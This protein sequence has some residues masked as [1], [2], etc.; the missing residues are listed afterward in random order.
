MSISPPETG[1]KARYD[2]KWL[3]AWTRN[4]TKCLKKVF[5]RYGV[6]LFRGF[7][8]QDPL[9]FE[10]VALSVVSW[11]WICFERFPMSIARSFSLRPRLLT[12]LFSQ[13]QVHGPEKVA[14]RICLRTRRFLNVKISIFNSWQKGTQLG[15]SISGNFT[16]KSNQWYFLCLH[17]CRLQPTSDGASFFFKSSSWVSWSHPWEFGQKEVKD[18]Q[19]KHHQNQRKPHIHMNTPNIGCE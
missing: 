13:Q 6:L 2:S 8:I 19:Q 14:H 5:F 3:S 10:E 12:H 7:D 15:T 17:S 4:H 1:E 9:A 18:W 16:K 11:R